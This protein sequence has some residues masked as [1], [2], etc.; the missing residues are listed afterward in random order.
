MPSLSPSRPRRSIFVPTAIVL[1]L[2]LLFC[3]VRPASAKACGAP[4]F[5]GM[6]EAVAI[7]VGVL[8]LVIAGIFVV[9]NSG[10]SEPS[11]VDKRTPADPLNQRLFFDAAPTQNGDGVRASVGGHF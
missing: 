2:A 11:E 8:G 3:A 4:S 9:A 1:A 10:K 5:D 7:D 6:G